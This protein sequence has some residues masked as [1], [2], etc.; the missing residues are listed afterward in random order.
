MLDEAYIE[1]AGLEQ[2]WR[3]GALARKPV[4]LRTFGK[5]AGLAGLRLGYGTFPEWFMPI[6]L[7][8]KQPY[9]VNVAA[10][11][12]GLVSLKHRGEIEETVDTLVRDSGC[13]SNLLTSTFFSQSQATRTSCCAVLPMAIR[14]SSNKP[15]R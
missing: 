6:L 4:V 2:S 10:T 5:W 7:K 15:W 12:A 14:G 9:N 1:F 11:V 13:R 3:V 8:T